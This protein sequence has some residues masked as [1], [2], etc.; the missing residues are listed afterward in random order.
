MMEIKFIERKELKEK[1]DMSTVTFGSTFTDY[2]LTA[3]YNEENGWHDWTIEPYGPIQLAPTA[4]VLHYA[5]TVFEGLKAY[6]VNGEAVLFRPNENFARLNRSLERM[7][8][9]KIDE[10]DALFALKELLKVEKDWIPT[11][12]GQS[13]YIR[14]FV[15]GDDHTLG[16]HPS[17]TYKFMILLSP[18]GGLFSAGTMGTTKI[19]VEDKFV[20]AVRGGVGEAKTGGNYLTS[21]KAQEVAQ[22]LGYDQVLWLDGVEQKYLEEVGAMNIFY[23]QN[24]ELF[25]PQLNGSILPGVTRKS[26]I[27]FAKDAGYTVNEAR[28][29]LEDLDAGLKDGSITE[30]FGAGT[31]A[32]VAP[33][34]ELNI[35]GN[36]YVVGDGNVGPVAKEI[37]TT[38][39]GIQNG[40]VEDK[41]NWIVKV[42]E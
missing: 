38:L 40:K 3:S 13:L 20:R 5:Q 25:T 41:F 26:I 7:S 30:V 9:A 21:M 35:H 11:G 19:Y 32:V 23:V 37:Y 31:A 6:N 29:P 34:G 4:V 12:E 22:S 16:V 17:T 2:M 1:P 42:D 15:F 39:T 28:I 33:V 27:E 24:G 10:D 14:P 18:V 36:K 8:M